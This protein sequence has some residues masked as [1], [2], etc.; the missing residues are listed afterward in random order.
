MVEFTLLED[1]VSIKFEVNSGCRNLALELGQAP[2]R[3]IC[4]V[5]SLAAFVAQ[6]C[7]SNVG[8]LSWCV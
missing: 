7:V 4:N 6:N 8:L 3:M 2:L 5:F 1:S